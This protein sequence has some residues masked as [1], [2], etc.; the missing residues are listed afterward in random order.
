MWHASAGAQGI[1]LGNKTL[2]GYA[3]K[4]L[5]GVGDAELGEWVEIGERAVHLRRRLSEHEAGVVGPVMDVRGTPEAEQRLRYVRRLVPG[6][7]E[8][9]ES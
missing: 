6:Y 7:D 5:D 4:A 3:R 9:P 2:L 8:P 1:V